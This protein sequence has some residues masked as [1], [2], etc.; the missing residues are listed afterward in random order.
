MK[1]LKS[2]DRYVMV[3]AILNST[4]MNKSA[5]NLATPV[6]TALIWGRNVFP[7][8]NPALWEPTATGGGKRRQD[9]TAIW[10]TSGISAPM[11]HAGK[12]WAG[13]GA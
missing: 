4:A 12:P 2:S 1:N 6:C 9:F 10:G 8:A 7:A 5:V 11:R 13:S 3:P